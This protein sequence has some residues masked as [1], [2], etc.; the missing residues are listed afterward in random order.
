MVNKKMNTEAKPMTNGGSEF[1]KH[2]LKTALRVAQ[3]LE[4]KNSGN[5]MPPTDVAIA[6]DKSP[7]SSDFR[8]LL[9]SSIKYGLTTGSFNQAKITLTESARDIVAP[10]S[11]GAKNK[12]LL[13][14]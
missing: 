3:A 6:I 8:M 12:A 9:S 2:S 10:T 13:R 4:D 7:G 5:P 1:P 11:D 14:S